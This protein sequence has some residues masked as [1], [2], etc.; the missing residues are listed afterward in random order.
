MVGRGAEQ[1]SV[2]PAGGDARTVALELFRAERELLPAG[3]L[4]AY[5]RSGARPRVA[6]H[7]T[8]VPS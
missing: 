8:P 6:T 2:Q 5:T 3:G 1:L 4:L 7:R